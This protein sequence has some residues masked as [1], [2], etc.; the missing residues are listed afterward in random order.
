MEEHAVDAIV[1]DCQQQSCERPAFIVNDE[2]GLAVE[3]VF[4]FEIGAARAVAAMNAAIFGAPTSGALRLRNPRATMQ[5]RARRQT[6]SECRKRRVESPNP[7]RIVGN[8]ADHTTSYSAIRFLSLPCSKILRDS[9]SLRTC[10]KS[11]AAARCAKR[12]SSCA[13]SIRGKTNSRKW[14]LDASRVA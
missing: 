10:G 5:A 7:P 9:H 2:R 8:A 4:G 13:A 11:N 6:T 3:F 1:C 14:S 12:T